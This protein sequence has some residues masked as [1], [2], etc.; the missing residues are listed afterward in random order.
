MSPADA[1]RRP[2]VVVVGGGISGLAAARA[3]RAARPDVRVTVLEGA[4]RVGGKLRLAEVAGVNVD[5]GAEAMLNRRPEAVALT[6][7]AGLG[8][9][10][11]H[12]TAASPRI[13]TRRAL[14]PLPTGQVMGVPTDLRALART[15]VLSLPG[16]ARVP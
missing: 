6:R 3:V 5:V 14:R 9:D 12:P 13:W 1:V 8:D 15:G 4:D 7:A 2:H 11:V 16:M 10:L